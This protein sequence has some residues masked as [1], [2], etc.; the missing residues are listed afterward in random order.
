[1]DSS[2][3]A[4]IDILFTKGN[5]GDSLPFDGP[6]T[7]IAHAF[8]PHEGGDEHYDEDE[9]WTHQSSQGWLISMNLL[10]SLIKVMY[11]TIE[12]LQSH[13]PAPMFA[14]DCDA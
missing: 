8:F 9:D 6:G 14:A 10:F 5:H 1:M 4:E 13:D 2:I 7:I 3:I 11:H 12:A